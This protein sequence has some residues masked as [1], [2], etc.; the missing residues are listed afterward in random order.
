[1]MIDEAFKVCKELIKCGCKKGI[2]NQKVLLKVKFPQN[3]VAVAEI[4]KANLLI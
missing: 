4:V 1:M 3:Y 2:G